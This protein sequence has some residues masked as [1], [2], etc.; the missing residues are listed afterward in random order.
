M[1]K[2]TTEEFILKAKKIHG[3]RYDYS[4]CVYNGS[5]SV[6]DIICD[7]HGVFQQTPNRHLNNRGC[8]KCGNI[9]QSN[10]RRKTLKHFIVKSKTIHGDKYD[11]SKVNYFDS[12]IN[13]TIICPEHGEFNQKPNNHLK[14]FGC[15]QCNMK[16]LGELMIINWLNRNNIKYEIQKSFSNCK[17]IIHLRYDFYLPNQKLLIEYDGEPHFK[18]IEYLGGKDGLM[19]RQIN[20]KIKT[21]Y[22]MN[23]NFNLLRIKYTERKNLSEILKNNIIII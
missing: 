21:D 15:S 4:K 16:S 10:S 5:F 22:A 1:K 14:G 7:K 20:D 18:E 13:V 12:R 3:N 6:V 17:N 23:N 8:V 2:L 9:K 11:Y 19:Y